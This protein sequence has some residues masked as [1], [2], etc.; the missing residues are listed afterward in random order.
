MSQVL[1]LPVAITY[2]NC[3]QHVFEAHRLSYL[4]SMF[5]SAQSIASRSRWSLGNH[6]W[7]C[8]RWAFF[9]M[10]F[11]FPFHS[12]MSLYVPVRSRLP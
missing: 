9:L 6:D 2:E 3:L 4:P 8:L 5:S 12:R 1:T 11:F 7:R 10:T